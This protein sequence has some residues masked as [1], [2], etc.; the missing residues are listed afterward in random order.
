M[1]CNC[2]GEEMKSGEQASSTTISPLGVCAASVFLGIFFAG[3]LYKLPPY[4]RVRVA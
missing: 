1:D 2:C 3:F 4:I